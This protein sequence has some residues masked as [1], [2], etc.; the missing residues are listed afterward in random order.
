MCEREKEKEKERKERKIER[1]RKKDLRMV[2][3]GLC[4]LVLMCIYA[5]ALFTWTSS[6]YPDSI[7]ISSLNWDACKQV[8]CD[9]CRGSGAKSQKHVKKCGE[10]NG[11]G[12]RIVTHQLGPGFVQQ[13]QQQCVIWGGN[14]GGGTSVEAGGWCLFIII[15]F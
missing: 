1:E 4:F 13:M 12:F 6:T 10:C 14:G 9:K 11:Q 8:V 5:Y 7:F 2:L 3:Q 15:I